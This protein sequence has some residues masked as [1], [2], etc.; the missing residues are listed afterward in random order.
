[1]QLK[2][3][4][5]SHTAK[6]KSIISD[7]NNSIFIHAIRCS[8]KRDDVVVDT[9]CILEA[10]AHEHMNKKQMHSNRNNKNKNKIKTR[11]YTEGIFPHTFGG[12]QC[13]PWGL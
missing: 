1:M 9:L 7:I 6:K 4:K 12:H 8:L 11:R 2:K 3:T 10:A 5:D 13:W